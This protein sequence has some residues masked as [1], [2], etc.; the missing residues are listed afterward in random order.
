MAAIIRGPNE[1]GYI[2]LDEDA[3]LAATLAAET[4]ILWRKWL[5]SKFE[6]R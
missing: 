3:E 6:K 1:L 4:F 5:I 2:E